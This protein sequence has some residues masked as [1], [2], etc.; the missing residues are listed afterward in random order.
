MMKRDIPKSP[1]IV[2]TENDDLAKAILLMTKGTVLK[3]RKVDTKEDVM[4]PGTEKEEVVAEAV[5]EDTETEDKK[6]WLQFQQR[7][8][9]S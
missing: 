5:I 1:K 6:S 3:D 7:K 2:T 4:I 8:I 9:H